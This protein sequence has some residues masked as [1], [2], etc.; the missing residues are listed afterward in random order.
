MKTAEEMRAISLEKHTRD[1]EKLMQALEKAASLG[2]FWTE[3]CWENEEELFE[4]VRKFEDK[5]VLKGY[6]IE[7]SDSETFHIS[8]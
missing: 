5:L 8:W 4:L 6:E 1:E 3:I 2:H 7:M